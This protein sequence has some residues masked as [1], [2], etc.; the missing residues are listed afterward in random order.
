MDAIGNFYGRGGEGCCAA[1]GRPNFAYGIP[2]TGRMIDSTDLNPFVFAAFGA[3]A[4]AWRLVRSGP[5]SMLVLPGGV[6]WKPPSRGRR[7]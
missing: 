4:Q 6:T 3:A 1:Q 5:T 7:A 2:E